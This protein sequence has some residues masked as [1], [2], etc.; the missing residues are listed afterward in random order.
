MANAKKC[1]RCG[2]F[3]LMGFDACH[4]V[5]RRFDGRNHPLEVDLCE[6]CSSELELFLG[7]NSVVIADQEQANSV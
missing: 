7:G 1:D 5:Y 3:Y 6:T 4:T 2:A